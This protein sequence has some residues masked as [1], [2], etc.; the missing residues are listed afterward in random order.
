MVTQRAQA[1]QPSTQRLDCRM[2]GCSTQIE[3][4]TPAATPTARIEA[5]L[6]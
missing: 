4:R 6:S 3:A 2:S 1:T 5:A